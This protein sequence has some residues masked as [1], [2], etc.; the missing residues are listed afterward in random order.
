MTAPNSKTTKYLDELRA[1]LQ[2]TPA[3]N[4]TANLQLLADCK[5]QMRSMSKEELIDAAINSANRD[6]ELN[7]IFLAPEQQRAVAVLHAGYALEIL[8]ERFKDGRC[9]VEFILRCLPHLSRATVY[10]YLSLAKRYPDPR[11]LKD[12]KKLA[13][14]R[15]SGSSE[16]AVLQVPNEKKIA[17]ASEEKQKASVFSVK[18]FCKNTTALSAMACSGAAW[19]PSAPLSDKDRTALRASVE[20]A[21]ANLQVF[22]KELDAISNLRALPASTAVHAAA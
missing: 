13:A 6:G 18:R 10:R 21:I 15:I 16:K 9:W 3:Y 22:A 5:K 2:V 20:D 1:A 11:V 8:Q 4:V 7:G 17:A 12:P 14:F 19:A